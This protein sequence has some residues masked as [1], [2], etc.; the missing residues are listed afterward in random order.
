MQQLTSKKRR[1]QFP[2]PKI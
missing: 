1:K 2:D